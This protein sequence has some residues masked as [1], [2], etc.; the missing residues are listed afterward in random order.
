MVVT[1]LHV[2]FT[3]TKIVPHTPKRVSKTQAMS[4]SHFSEHE[5]PFSTNQEINPENSFS[6]RIVD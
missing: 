2:Y 6:K 3:T 1:K 5:P 4:Y